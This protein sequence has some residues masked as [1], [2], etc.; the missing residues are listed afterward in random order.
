MKEKNFRYDPYEQR[1][2]YTCGPA[3]LLMAY[4]YLG[5]NFLEEDIAE[6]LHTD[7]EGTSWEE[8]IAHPSNL[9]YRVEF[10]SNADWEDLR[11]NMDKGVVCVSWQTDRYGEPDGHFSLVA[12]MTDDMIE[13]ANPG[14]S[15]DKWP[16]IF[17][18]QTFMSKWQD[19]QLSK[20]FM[21]IIPK[22]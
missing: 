2:T 22:R 1:K 21:V 4:K 13:L 15:I 17:D 6:K 18:K 16:D 11:R 10:T 3:T 14:L 9:G 8:L 5:K 19:E 20:C 12:D 7:K